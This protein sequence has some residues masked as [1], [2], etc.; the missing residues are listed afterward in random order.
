VLQELGER[1]I[2]SLLVEGG[3]E[4]NGSFLQARA[5]QKVVSYLSLKLIGGSSAPS[6]FG[7]KGF[8]T[9]D[10]AV[11]LTDVQMESVGEQDIRMVGYPKWR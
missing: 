3:A 5:I 7:G 6:P 8:A 11:A 4:I 2:T 1:G 9:M 10:E